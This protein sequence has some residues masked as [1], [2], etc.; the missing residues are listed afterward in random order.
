[1][2]P[3]VPQKWSDTLFSSLPAIPTPSISTP[4]QTFGSPKYAMTCARVP[5]CF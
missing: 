4:L 5:V 1:M 3:H 2:E